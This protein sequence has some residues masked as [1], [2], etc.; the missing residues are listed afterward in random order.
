MLSHLKAQTKDVRA[1]TGRVEVLEK[2]ICDTKVKQ[3][4]YARR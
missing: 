2:I 1:L 3:A 4:E